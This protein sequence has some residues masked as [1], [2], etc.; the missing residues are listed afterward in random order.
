VKITV[1]DASALLALFYDEAGAE[2]V[3][4]LFQQAAEA[5][6]PLSIASIN[7]AEVLYMLQRKD[8]HL[9]LEAA[10]HFEAMMPLEVVPADRNLADEAA[11]LKNH[12]NLGLADAFAAALAREKKAEFVTG[13]LEFKVLEKEVRIRWLS[14]RG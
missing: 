11:G 2:Q 10:R 5:D 14:K 13:D 8:G 12:Y 4:G 6:E 3:E 7:W 1:L 9:G